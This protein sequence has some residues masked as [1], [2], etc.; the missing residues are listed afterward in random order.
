MFNRY[1]LA[2]NQM[3]GPYGLTHRASIHFLVNMLEAYYFAHCDA[4]NVAAGAEILAQDHPDDVESI[5]HPKN[6]LKQ[7]WNGFDEVEH[8]SAILGQLDLDRV[9]QHNER[10]C[11][12]RTLFHWCISRIPLASVWDTQL[13]QQFRLPD[14]CR[15]SLTENQQI[16]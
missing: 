12:L 3:L 13:L 6:Q 1:R 5:G 9:L 2:L 4:V 16:V 11:W 10:C 15:I 8:G 7:L 14:G